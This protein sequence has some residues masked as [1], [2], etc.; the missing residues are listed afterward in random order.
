MN[1]GD[2][3]VIYLSRGG[4]HACTR[5]CEVIDCRSI[6]KIHLSMD[7]YFFLCVRTSDHEIDT[8]HCH[9]GERNMTFGNALRWIVLIVI[10]DSRINDGFENDIVHSENKI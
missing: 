9:I 10:L 3:I 4:S 5:H 2:I 6:H 8:V 7:T 1:S